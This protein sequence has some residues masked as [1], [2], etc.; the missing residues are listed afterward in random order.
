[1]LAVAFLGEGAT[2]VVDIGNGDD[3][4]TRQRRFGLHVSLA[5]NAEADAANL[6][7]IVSRDRFGGFLC[8]SSLG[9]GKRGGR[10]AG[11]LQEM[12]TTDGHGLMCSLKR[13]TV[14]VQTGGLQSPL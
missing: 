8:G 14:E 11:T 9:H 13:R 10:N 3:F 6:N 12:A 4:D 2:T 1:V 5:H 7:A